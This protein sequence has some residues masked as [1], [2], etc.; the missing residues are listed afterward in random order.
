MNIFKTARDGP[1]AYRAHH[2]ALTDEFARRKLADEQRAAEAEAAATRGRPTAEE[3]EALAKARVLAAQAATTK[4]NAEIQQY[5]D[6]KEKAL[7]L[8]AVA[9][10]ERNAALASRDVEAAV[11]AQ[12]RVIAAGSL[13]ELIDADVRRRFPP[14]GLHF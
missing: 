6:L 14:T 5:L 12:M 7:G 4:R 13:P 2:R 11:T 8:A 3:A 9:E 1:E 10:V